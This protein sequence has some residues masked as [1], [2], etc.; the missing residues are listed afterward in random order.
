MLM[1]LRVLTVLAALTACAPNPGSAPGPES[2]SSTPSGQAATSAEVYR[3]A[4]LKSERLGRALYQKDI[5]TAFATDMLLRG[6]YLA[7][8]Q[9]ITGWV[10]QEGEGSM[11]VTYVAEDSGR[12]TVGHEVVFPGGLTNPPALAPTE[13]NTPLIG[14]RAVM[15]EARTTAVGELRPL[16][17]TNYNTVVLPG[18]LIGEQGWLVYLLASTV[19]PGERVL[20]GHTVVRVSPDGLI[21]L[22]TTPLSLSCLIVPVDLPEGTEQTGIFVTHLTTS[23]PLETHVYTSLLYSVPVYVRTQTGT[24]LVENGKIELTDL[25]ATQ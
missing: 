3:E 21:P 15:Y 22:G 25:A 6:G 13:P 7:G 8:D 11:L 14:E 9:T 17:D 23:W 10:T 24:W 20:A 12:R 1:R 18:T 5:A 2:A 19:N 4:V 16:C